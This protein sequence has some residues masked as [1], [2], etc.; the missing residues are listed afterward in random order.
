MIQGTSSHAGKSVFVAALLRILK[1]KGISCAP[2]KPQNMALNSFVT[3]EGFEIGRAQAMQAEAAGAIPSVDMNPVLL[4]PTADSKAQVIVC[5]KPWK[6]MSAIEYQKRKKELR[7]FVKD[8]FEKLTRAYEVV[9]VEGAGSP[10]EINLRKD[11]LANMGFAM[12]YSLPVL[13]VG[14]I[15]R[16]GVYASFYGTYA[17]LTPKERQLVKGFIINK[18]RGDK[19]LLKPANDFI[20]KKTGVSVLGVI[21]YFAD[22]LINDEDGVSLTEGRKKRASSKNNILKIRIIKLPRIS[23]FTD[24]EP[25]FIEDDVDVAYVSSPQECAEADFVII[26]GS[27]NTI[28]DL[29]FLKKQGFHRF[30]PDF[31][32]N[33]GFL[34]GICGGYQMLGKVVKDP[35]GVETHIKET[36]GLGILDTETVLEKDKKLKQVEFRTADGY[37]KDMKGYEI[38]MGITSINS[39][40]PLF[41]IEEGVNGQ[42][43]GVEICDGRVFGTYIHGVFD[44]DKFRL[45]ILNRIRKAKGLRTVKKTFNY[46]AYKD[47]AYN[48]LAELVES[49]LKIKEVLSLLGY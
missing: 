46:L 23:N 26:P 17:L 8:S 1:N 10:A 32:K 41:L 44:N 38:H 34:A 31:V 13:I 45:H 27:K 12:M 7:Q 43:D 35:Y 28:E 22:L 18:F 11:D 16:G 47:R 6:N 9:V 33:G 40:K 21:P 42:Y 49:S 15:D 19:A 20:E 5:G 36:E 4:K 29:M 48:S 3:P 24:F 25:F 37:L 30:L 14:D 39:G 2:F